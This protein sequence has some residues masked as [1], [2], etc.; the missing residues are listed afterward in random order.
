MM[1]WP[2]ALRRLLAQVP[3]SLEWLHSPCLLRVALALRQ[4]APWAA[5]TFSLHSVVP[6]AGEASDLPLE[7]DQAG[8]C[9]LAMTSPVLPR[10]LWPLSRM[11]RAVRLLPP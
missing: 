5:I 3:G 4:P 11:Q 7:Q 8:P 6:G 1:S 2:I 9:A 10:Y